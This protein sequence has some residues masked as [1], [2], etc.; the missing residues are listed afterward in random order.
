[1]EADME[2]PPRGPSLPIDLHSVND[3]L[4]PKRKLGKVRGKELLASW[5]RERKPIVI[6][7]TMTWAQ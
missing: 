3:I 1:M 2:I 4:T 5:E 6:V 7:P